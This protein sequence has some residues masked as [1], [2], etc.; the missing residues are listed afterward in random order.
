MFTKVINILGIILIGIILVNHII[1]DGVRYRT[2]DIVYQNQERQ[3]S[4]L[5]LRF[6]DQICAMNTYITAIQNKLIELDK[7]AIKK[8]DYNSQSTLLIKADGSMYI[9]IVIKDEPT[10]QQYLRDGIITPWKECKGYYDM[11]L[12]FKKDE[13]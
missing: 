11:S 10:K 7:M 4:I 6:S 9:P 1:N 5:T 3:L 13:K 8:N 2:Q 12:I